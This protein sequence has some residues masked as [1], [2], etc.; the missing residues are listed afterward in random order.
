MTL[1]GVAKFEGKL[2]RGLR[3]DIRYLVNF[4]ASGQKF[5]N[6]HS[7]RLLLYKAYKDFDESVQKWYVT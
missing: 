7:D 4:L 6:L 2:T 1:K 3:N 5:G